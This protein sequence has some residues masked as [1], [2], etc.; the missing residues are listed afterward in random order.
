MIYFKCSLEE[1]T[2][3]QRKDFKFNYYN[4]Y[5]WRDYHKKIKE[6]SEAWVIIGPTNLV[7]WNDAL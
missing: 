5:I 7:E 1:P 4:S 6:V 2:R 3:L